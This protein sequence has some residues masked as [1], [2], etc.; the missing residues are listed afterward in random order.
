MGDLSQVRALCN[1]PIIVTGEDHLK[2]GMCG[3]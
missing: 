3:W 1:K 2:R